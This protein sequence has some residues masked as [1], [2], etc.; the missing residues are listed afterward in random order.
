M[1]MLV[2]GL[3]ALCGAPA[4]AQCPATAVQDAV[5]VWAAV[6]QGQPQADAKPVIDDLAEACKADA[7]VLKVAALTNGAMSARATAPD[8]ILA[9]GVKARTLAM[10]MRDVQPDNEKQVSA[11]VGQNWIPIRI[12]GDNFD[13]DILLAY[14]GAQQRSGILAAEATALTSGEKLRSCR[15]WDRVDAQNIST[16]IRENLKTD[17]TAPLNV[18]DRLIAICASRIDAGQDDLLLG[19]RA[20]AYYQLLSDNP[21]RDGGTA[22]MEKLQRDSKRFFELNPKGDTVYWSTYDRDRLAAFS[23]EF[24]IA[25]GSLPPRPEWFKPGNTENMRVIRSIALALDDAWAIDEPKGVAGKYQNYR[26]LVAALYNEAIKSGNLV[27]AKQALVLAATGQ[28][29]G[30]MRRSANKQRK[31][32][33]DFLWSWL[34]PASNPQ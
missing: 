30:S 23:V 24:D 20:R 21:Q 4:V 18:L 11:Q 14:F 2:L 17:L 5:N 29:D 1:R 19:L 28:S 6:S 15:S 33:P 10:A 16:I 32:P 34:Q 26:D 12:F 25:T 31:A 3:I 7:Y 13:K 22:M 9:H 27:A 8:Q